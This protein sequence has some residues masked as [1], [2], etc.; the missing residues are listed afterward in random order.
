MEAPAL[1]AQA[2]LNQRAVNVRVGGR[3]SL[4][5]W[6]DQHGSRREFACRTSRV[7]PFRMLVS[8]PV[9]GK[10]G[11]RVVSHFGEFGQLDG[12]IA[13][14]VEGGFLVDLDADKAQRKKLARKLS[15]L[16]KRQNDPSLVEARVETDAS[17][18][19][20]RIRR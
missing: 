2:F 11:D 19:R 14:T 4:A 20:S 15:W 3:Y 7:S 16:E 1:S 18:R 10:V 17:S 12:W 8:V 6:F 13:D 5:N 9:I